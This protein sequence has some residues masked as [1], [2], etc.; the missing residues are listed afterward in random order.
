MSDSTYASRFTEKAN[1]KSV[2]Y[3]QYKILLSQ[4]LPLNN[5][6]SNQFNPFSNKYQQLGIKI[7]EN[8]Y[9]SKHGFLKIKLKEG[10][11][12]IDELMT[13]KRKFV[14]SHYLSLLQNQHYYPIARKS[15][16][17]HE[18]HKK[19]D[20][21]GFMYNTFHEFQKILNQT[22][23]IL[24]SRPTDFATQFGNNVRT[25]SQDR[26]LYVFYMLS[27]DIQISSHYLLSRII[28]LPPPKDPQIDVLEL[29]TK[30]ISPPNNHKIGDISDK[31]IS[32]DESTSIL[33]NKVDILDFRKSLQ[34]MEICR[35][36]ISKVTKRIS[37][38]RSTRPLL[39]NKPN[40]QGFFSVYERE[41]LGSESYP[42]TDI[43]S[44]IGLR[45]RKKQ[46]QAQHEFAKCEIGWS[47]KRIPMRRM[48][49]SSEDMFFEKKSVGNASVHRSGSN[50]S[51]SSFK[52]HSIQVSQ[53]STVQQST[54]NQAS[55]SSA[56]PS[57]TWLKEEGT[58]PFRMT[59]FKDQTIVSVKS[60][61]TFEKKGGNDNLNSNYAND[62]DES[63]NEDSFF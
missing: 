29:R 21:F 38:R 35:D 17:L 59:L 42:R 16:I 46:R 14:G 6:N 43:L 52:S 18:G 60:I 8:K 55:V 53:S 23:E 9:S 3:Q 13:R 28:K 19:N 15:V 45:I 26:F 58:D 48:L 32:I 54:T 24:P 51:I 12:I 44:F 22:L 39:S 1:Q 40:D 41:K 30:K 20:L 57:T 31:H 33:E 2:P 63:D 11:N 7:P 34:K 62:N 5:N 61:T 50:S 47:E 10:N 56:S 4:P 37:S 49:L 25:E 36:Q 27:F